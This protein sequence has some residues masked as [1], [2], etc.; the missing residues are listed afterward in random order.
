MSSNR[1]P[2]GNELSENHQT[3]NIATIDKLKE[4]KKRVLRR[5]STSSFQHFQMENSYTINNISLGSLRNDFSEKFYNSSKFFNR[6]SQS[7]SQSSGFVARDT[8]PLRFRRSS[9][10]SRR[11][12]SSH[13]ISRKSLQNSLTGSSIE[14]FSSSEEDDSTMV[15]K[16]QT[17]SRPINSSHEI[18][19]PYWK[20]YESLNQMY[21]EFSESMNMTFVCQFHLTYATSCCHVLIEFARFTSEDK[22]PL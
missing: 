20:E 9:K 4:L 10:A 2:N 3:L 8:Y 7:A 6:P 16:H 5:P 14:N 17:D 15:V 21:L 1:S 11:A 13:R 22:T 19:V 12:Y 18:L